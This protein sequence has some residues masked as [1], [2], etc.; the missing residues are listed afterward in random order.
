M[1]KTQRITS[2]IAVVAYAACVLAPGA[3]LA[4]S[5]QKN[6]NLWRNLAIG[7]GVVAAH[8]L[9]THNG[10]ETLIGAAGAAYSANRY[11]HER[12]SQSARHRARWHRYHH[13]HHHKVVHHH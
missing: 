6:K 11:E 4:D 1:T 5:Q 3:A 7:G 13:Y 2:L 10:T 9:I 8:G 12:R